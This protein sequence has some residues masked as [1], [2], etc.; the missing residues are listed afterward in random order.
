MRS[1]LLLTLR[2]RKVDLG[3]AY[4]EAVRTA[5]HS[6]WRTCRRRALRISKVDLGKAYLKAGAKLGRV[7]CHHDFPA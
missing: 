7:F 5:P 1:G 6:Q 4:R 3:Q 2:I